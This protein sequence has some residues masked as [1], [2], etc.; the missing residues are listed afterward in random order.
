MHSPPDQP[1]SACRERCGKMEGGKRGEEGETAGLRGVE[2]CWVVTER[3]VS[4]KILV[5]PTASEGSSRL[6]KGVLV[7]LTLYVR[8]H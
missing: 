4:E 1:N 6:R 3:C 5:C 8:V 2:G 7:M